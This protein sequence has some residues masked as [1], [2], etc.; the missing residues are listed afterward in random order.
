MSADI[1]VIIS[2]YNRAEVLRRTL[3]EFTAVDVSGL[4]VQWVVIDN[5][6]TDETPQ[7]L[8]EAPK[9]LELV[10]LS[11]DRPG[12]GFALNKVLDEVELAPVVAFSDDDV[13]PEPDWL[14]RVV[15]SCE[16]WPE[17]SVFGGRVIVD[18][19][20]DPPPPWT[21]PRWIQVFGFA[22]H[23]LS[24]DEGPYPEAGYPF[25]PNFWLRRKVIDEGHR[26][27]E[28]VGPRPT[29]RIMGGETM[30]LVELERVGYKPVYVPS[31]I[32]HHRIQP[33]AMDFKKFEKRAF[34]FGRGQYYCFGPPDPE[35]LA[36]S[37]GRWR[38]RRWRAIG[39]E[40]LRYAST[41]GR[42]GSAKLASRRIYAISKIALNREALREAKAGKAQ[43]W[44]GVS[45]D[46]AAGAPKDAAARSATKARSGAAGVPGSQG[47]PFAAEAERALREHGSGDAR[48]GT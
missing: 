22:L 6:S 37:P 15:E 23:D 42:V 29:N 11:D 44:G 36:S 25:G 26:F 27:D 45:P 33:E 46:E 8:A 2:T 32:V 47:E 10:A 30:L 24:Q 16:R 14:K 1:S 4:N 18:W 12:R 3:R 39:R 7:V 17:H 5:A 28:K 21:Q 20:V 38:R 9:E 31:A 34:R 13:T 48:D 19:P 35:S 40:C 43:H 41:L